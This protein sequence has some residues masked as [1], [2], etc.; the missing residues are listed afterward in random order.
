MTPEAPGV[1]PVPPGWVGLAGARVE[2]VEVSARDGLQNDAAELPTAAKV[3][4]IARLAAVGLRRL[5]ATSF[6]S[7]RAVPKM[8][9]AEEL[10]AALRARSD[11]DGVT[12]IGLVVNQRGVARAAA[13]G[14]QE[15]NAVVVTTDTFSEA[16]Q[17]A[18]TAEYLE[19]LA[20]LL[21]GARLAGLRTSVTVAAAFGCPFEGEV[22]LQRLAW[23]LE[24]VAA[25]GPDEIALADTI[26]VAVP[27]EVHARFALL[28]EVLAGTALATRPR[29]RA[30]FH[31]TRNTGVANALSA[32]G[33]GVEALDVSLG[34]IGGC[35]FAPAATGNLATEDL[36]Y[37]L[38]RS[39]AVTGVSLPGLLE[40]ASWL[41]AELGHPVASSL[42]R[43]G[44][45][46]RPPGPG[47]APAVP[48]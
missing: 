29:R 2:L 31:D 10:V 38:E 7:P 32:V 41:A 15:V 11:L 40:H 9:D 18:A 44:P 6:V 23:V 33:A 8:A 21:A 42:S 3:E 5:E 28:D 35:P 22:P 20:D 45:W 17:G 25:A 14:V 16:N 48:S 27:A 19:G 4:L 39:G 43:A 36:V 24:A 37:A 30:H 47:T 34:G 13:A 46:P 1:V 26:G 12:L